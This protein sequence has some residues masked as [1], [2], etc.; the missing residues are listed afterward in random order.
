MMHY[1]LPTPELSIPT[2]RT[3][4]TPFTTCHDVVQ[5]LHDW[6]VPASWPYACCRSFGLFRVLGTHVIVEEYANECAGRRT[7]GKRHKV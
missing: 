5:M 7:A 1:L 4:S 6:A 3:A 2:P